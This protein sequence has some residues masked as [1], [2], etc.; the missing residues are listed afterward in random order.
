MF[1][2]SC[3]LVQVQTVIHSV[4]IVEEERLSQLDTCIPFC[5][6]LNRNSEFIKQ[7][8][9]YELLSAKAAF[10]AKISKAPHH[11]TRG[12]CGSA[13]RRGPKRMGSN[14]LPEEIIESFTPQYDKV[15]RKKSSKNSFASNRIFRFPPCLSTFLFD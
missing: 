7:I 14:I 10:A 9:G 5:P 4:L 8:M 13:T 1:S 2:H 12:K 3:Q 11:P 6:Q 15:K